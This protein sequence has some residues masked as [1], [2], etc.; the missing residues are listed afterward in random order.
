MI[1]HLEPMYDDVDT[2]VGYELGGFTYPLEDIT[3]SLLV[4]R[5]VFKR[6]LPW[7]GIRIPSGFGIHHPKLCQLLASETAPQE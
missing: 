6:N 3:E 5:P 4:I 7:C 2:E 1:R